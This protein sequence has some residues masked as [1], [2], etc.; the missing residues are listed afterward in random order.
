MPPETS[1]F[2]R[3]VIR[4]N[5]QGMAVG[6]YAVCSAHPAVLDAAIHQS[7]Q[8][9]TVLHVESTSNQVNQF[10]GYSGKHSRSVYRAD[11]LDG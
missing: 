3:E 2:L 9:E 8:D 1:E 7:L 6:I 4:R 5:R 11:T 10:G